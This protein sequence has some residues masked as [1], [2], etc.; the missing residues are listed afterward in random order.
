[1]PITC[2]KCG[3]A[4]GPAEAAPDW[5]CPA[6]GV[7]YAKVAPGAAPFVPRAREAASARAPGAALAGKA[8]IAAVALALLWA[9]LRPGEGERGGSRPEVPPASGAGLAASVK[10][11]DVVVYTTTECPHC[12]IA[13]DWLARYGFAFTECN[14]SVEPRCEDEFRRLGGRATPFVIVRGKPLSRG[15]HSREFLA[16]VAGRPS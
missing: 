13:K 11:G 9:F 8:A 4:R 1:V 3:H 15:F 12:R 5:Q 14:M 7:A 6:C 16:A 10:P 2:P